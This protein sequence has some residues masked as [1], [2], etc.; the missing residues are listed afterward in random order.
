MVLERVAKEGAEKAADGMRDASQTA[1]DAMGQVGSSNERA[2][3]TLAD[4]AVQA[5]DSIS[6]S[7]NGMGELVRDLGRLGVQASKSAA[8]SE[9]SRCRIL[10]YSLPAGVNAAARVVGH[11]IDAV[12]AV[13]DRRQ[14]G[15]IRNEHAQQAQLD[16]EHQQRA[17]QR[18]HTQ[19]EREQANELNVSRHIAAQRIT[20][21]LG[22][23][24]GEAHGDHCNTVDNDPL[25]EKNAIPSRA[26]RSTLIVGIA[27][28]E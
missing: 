27:S 23:R 3:Q 2:A 13:I 8:Y 12:P 5:S 20:P 1:A 6:D 26:P 28:N 18:D 21:L 14:L 17:G 7:T 25:Q 15:P 11:A 10:I 9:T 22:H 19:H 16:T 4:G 24:L